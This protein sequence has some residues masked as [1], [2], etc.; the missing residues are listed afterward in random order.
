MTTLTPLPPA[1]GRVRHAIAAAIA[2]AALLTA[3]CGGNT[4]PV[5]ATASAPGITPTTVLIGS[6]QALSGPAAPGFDEIAPAS[7]AFFSY[8]NAR[9]GIN[10]RKITYTVR[11]NAY[12]PNRAASADRQL[13]SQ[14]GVFAIFNAFGNPTH[15]AAVDGLNSQGV[16]DLFVDSGCGCWNEPRQRPETFGFETSYTVEGRLLGSYVARTYAGQRVAYIW[17]NDPIACCQVG[18]QALDSQIPSSQV[19]MR[20]SYTL[21]DLAATRLLPQ[22][23]AAKASG[24]QVLVLYTLPQ[25]TALVLLAAANLDY[26]PQILVA[27]IQSSD[28]STVGLY[29][30]RFS[31]GRAGVAMEN[32]VS[33]LDYLPSSSD[34]DNSWVRLFRQVHDTYEPQQ[35]FDNMTVYGMAAAYTFTR[36]LRLAGRNPTRQSIVAAVNSGAVNADG[37]G[38]ASFDFS[39]GNHAGFSGEQVGIVRDGGIVLSGPVYVTHDTG[40]IVVRRPSSASPPANF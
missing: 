33:T 28:P 19:V 10:G 31:G 29:L 25:A 18:V 35:P 6:D 15:A 37:P 38:L 9:G 5:T 30:Q 1:S 20:Q 24:A 2:G 26:H 23:Q 4:S 39:R 8:V 17:E 12:D 7:S 13:V 27:S 3:A 22:M 32:G 16:P 36:A 14:D 21:A 11:D 34:A 40:P